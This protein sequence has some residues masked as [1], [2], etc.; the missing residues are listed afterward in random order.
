MV[1]C[2]CD[3]SMSAPAFC[4]W[5]SEKSFRFENT[6]I[7][8]LTKTKKYQISTENI[9]SGPVVEYEN[10]EERWDKIS[11]WVIDKLTN[12]KAF[13]IEGFSYG[14]TSSTFAQICSN[15]AV[16][17]HKVYKHGIPIYIDSP[18]SIKKFAT[19]KGNAKK[20]DMFEAFRKETNVD[21][22][23]IFNA[24]PTLEEPLAGIVDSYYMCKYL[25]NG[26][27]LI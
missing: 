11:D 17:K 5:D 12:V 8:F 9:Y 2:A 22:H 27:K 19:G 10:H 1:I 24:P 16:L 14:S 25:G 4:L 26:L 21:L 20:P 7:Y 18:A 13:F 15:A 6:T 3:L 23:V